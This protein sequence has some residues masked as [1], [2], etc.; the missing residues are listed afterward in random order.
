MI[1]LLLANWRLVGIAL[2]VATVGA[3]CY[4]L[5]RKHV[6]AEFNAYKAAQA[7]E[8]ARIKG[9]QQERE[10]MWT[11]AMTVAG[12]QYD[13]QAKVADQSFDTS[14]DRLRRAYA[15]TN[16]VRPAAASA[17]ECPEPSGPTAADLLRAGETLAGIARDADR[18]RAALV[19]CVAGWPR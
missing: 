3:S 16:R 1:T 9:Q 6:R 11:Q 5:G 18:D 17:C 13:E 10:R 8:V 12:K 7:V 15:S 14:L 4:V 19:S 2:L